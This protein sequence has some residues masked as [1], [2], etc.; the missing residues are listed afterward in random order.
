[1]QTCPFLRLLT[2]AYNKNCVDCRNETCMRMH[3]IGLD[4]AGNPLPEDQRTACGAKTRDGIACSMPIV[5]GK[6]RCRA[7][8]G[9]STG[10]RT[11]AGRERISAAQQRRWEKA[12]SEKAAT[13]QV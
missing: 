1:M 8:G 5:P 11:K 2:T 13:N 9:L 4:I 6:P 7:H 10:P 12:K 3:A